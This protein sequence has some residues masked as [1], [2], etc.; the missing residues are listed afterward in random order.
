MLN[1]IPQQIVSSPLAK[2]FTYQLDKHF[3]RLTCKILYSTESVQYILFLKPPSHILKDKMTEEKFTPKWGHGK[4]LTEGHSG[5]QGPK[6]VV[7]LGRYVFRG[8]HKPLRQAA[9]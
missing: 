2:I 5:E 9:L 8:D 3:V 4:K 6:M 1:E 7:L